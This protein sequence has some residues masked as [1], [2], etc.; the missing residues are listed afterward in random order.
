MSNL[1][2]RYFASAVMTGVGNGSLVFS[3]GG[4]PE[5]SA[6]LAPFFKGEKGEKGDAGAGL[7]YGAGFKIVGAE[8][9]YDFQSLTRG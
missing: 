4:N 5:L 8:L 6:A 7:N 2:P 9:R 1:A 3:P